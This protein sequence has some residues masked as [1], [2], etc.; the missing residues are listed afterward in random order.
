MF[1]GEGGAGALVARLRPTSERASAALWTTLSV[2]ALLLAWLIAAAVSE[3]IRSPQDVIG[4]VPGFFENQDVLA[5][6]LTSLRRLVVSVVL[7]FVVGVAI[8]LLMSLDPRLRQF[9]SVYVTAAL[10]IPAFVAALFA[11]VVFGLDSVGVYVAVS[12]VCFPFVTIA[13]LESLDDLDPK[14][15]E[16][17]G[18]Y[19]FSRAMEIRHVVLPSITPALIAALRNTNALAWKVIVVA[20]V[21]AARG[22]IGAEFKRAFGLF[23]LDAVMIWLFVFLLA[24]LAVELFVLR[25]L[26]RS[27]LAWRR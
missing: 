4:A 27:L 5:T 22:G 25:P 11:L 13:I 8:A 12:I 19:H 7:A 26:E 18:T 21:F 9:L 6:V 14:L 10:G 3:F 23:Q 17:A 2:L 1:G 20:E 15:V 16:M 24:I